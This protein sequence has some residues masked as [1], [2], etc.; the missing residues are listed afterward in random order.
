MIVELSNERK[1][2]VKIKY[3]TNCKFKKCKDEYNRLITMS[4]KERG[5]NVTISEIPEKSSTSKTIVLGSSMCN[6]QDIFDKKVAKGLAYLRAINQL[7][8]LNLIEE[9]EVKELRQFNLNSETF[10]CEAK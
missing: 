8:A 1:F 2:I 10:K 3:I 4:W 6:Y 7:K 9:Y 5:C